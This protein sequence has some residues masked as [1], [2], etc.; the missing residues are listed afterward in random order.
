ML[1]RFIK[2]NRLYT[3][4]FIISFFATFILVYYGIDYYREFAIVK[5][6]QK[7]YKYKTVDQLYVKYYED[8]SQNA[9][10]EIDIGEGNIIRICTLPIG[11]KTNKAY[12][13]YIIL[14]QHEDFLEEINEGNINDYIT[15]ASNPSCIIGDYWE[16]WSY[17]RN[18]KKYLKIGGDEIEVIASFKQISIKG[19]D[20]R[21]YIL[22]N[23]ID[24]KVLN[25]WY[26][27]YHGYEYLF[28]SI[29][30]NL[31]GETLKDRLESIWGDD[32]V[33][34]SIKD[35]SWLSAK[36]LYNNYSPIIRTFLLIMITLCLTNM[37]FLTFVWSKTHIYEYMI[38]KAFGLRILQL[39]PDILKQLLFYE[40]TGFVFMLISTFL[41]ELVVHSIN[42]WIENMTKGFLIIIVLFSIMTIVLTMVPLKWISKQEPVKIIMSKE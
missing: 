5:E 13:V 15:R 37:I 9:L 20:K 14:Y 33:G 22:G 28:K 2:M 42:V 16:K 7:F 35:S 12:N 31:S 32:A 34:I 30:G 8:D 4:L 21:L 18:G 36:N 17:L 3:V 10:E 11:T 23:T 41:F 39:V 19:Y 38:K 25:K 24:D 27:E 40:G 6:N 1:N 26:A 29:Y